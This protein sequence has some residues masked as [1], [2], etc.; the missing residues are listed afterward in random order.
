VKK[1]FFKRRG[2]DKL[3]EFKGNNKG[4]EDGGMGG[5]NLRSR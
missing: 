4:L 1:K 2:D 3:D 5:C